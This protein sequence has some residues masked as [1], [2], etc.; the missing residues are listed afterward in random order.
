MRD[1]FK[2]LIKSYNFTY[3]VP[4]EFLYLRLAPDTP[5]YRREYIANGI[6]AYLRDDISF[7][8]D[9]KDLQAALSS[10]L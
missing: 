3:D 2:E 1:N 5:Q 6:R 10:S 9:L 8:V 4:K 7:V